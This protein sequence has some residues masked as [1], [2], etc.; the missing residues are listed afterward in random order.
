[1]KQSLVVDCSV[2]AP[3]FIPVEQTPAYEA[4]LT[5]ILEKQVEMVV[6][7]LWWYEIM[8]VIKSAVRSERISDEDAK[9]VFMFF[10]KTA[11]RGSLEF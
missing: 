9:S 10:F 8:N 5:S 1:M 6:P 3:W 2:C 11:N 4:L 7:D